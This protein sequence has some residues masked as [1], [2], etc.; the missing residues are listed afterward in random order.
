LL[1]C[2]SGDQPPS[3]H[4]LQVH[5]TP[6]FAWT[7]G[8]SGLSCTQGQ[9]DDDENVIYLIDDAEAL[10]FVLQFKIKVHGKQLKL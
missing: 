3:H 6:G 4:G 5:T 8:Q 2:P 1:P 9:G 7:S 10:E